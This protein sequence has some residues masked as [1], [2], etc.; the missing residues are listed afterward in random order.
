MSSGVAA[1]LADDI[2]GL[3]PAP[4]VAER[5]YSESHEWALLGIIRPFKLLSG[6]ASTF[7]K[8]RNKSQAE[9]KDTTSP[10]CC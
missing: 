8:G 1:K 2:A 3:A 6:S 10:L 9:I 5:Y 4:I 7:H